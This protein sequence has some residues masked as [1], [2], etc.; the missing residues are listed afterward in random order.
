VTERELKEMAGMVVQGMKDH[1]AI[2]I[3]PEV[4]ADQH[5]F[6]ALLMQERRDRVARRKSIEDKIAG[7]LVLSLVVGLVTLLGAGALDWLRGHLK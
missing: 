1:H 5:E 2:W 6:I 4:H 3:D 7:S